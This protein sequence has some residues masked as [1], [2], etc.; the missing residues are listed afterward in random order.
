MSI[1]DNGIGFSEDTAEKARLDNH[2]GIVS[3]RERTSLLNGTFH[4]DST[5]NDGTRITIILPITPKN[6]EGGL[7]DAESNQNTAGR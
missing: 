2:L 1:E 7:V 4:I 3:M 5:P 6:G